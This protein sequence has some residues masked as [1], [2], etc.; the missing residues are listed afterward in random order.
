MIFGLSEDTMQNV[1]CL[2]KLQEN[3][4]D[5][6]ACQF[7]CAST[8]QEVSDLHKLGNTIQELCEGMKFFLFTILMR[9]SPNYIRSPS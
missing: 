3:N 8:E 4:Q 5:D 1:M 9:G 7:F 6:L 2:L